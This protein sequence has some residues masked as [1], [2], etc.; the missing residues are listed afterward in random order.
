MAS[1]RD[2]TSKQYQVYLERWQKFCSRKNIDVL[3]PRVGEGIEFLV[4]LYKSGLGY[5]AINTARSALSSALTIQEGGTFGVHP[6]VSR[7]MKGIFELKPAL[8]RYSEIW[9]VDIVLAYLKGFSPLK[10]SLSFKD[11]T[12]NLNMLLCLT[13]GQR[14]QTIHKM[15]I[16]FIQEL[17]DGFRIVIN[18]KIKQTKPGKHLAPIV[19]KAYPEDK[20]ICV[21]DY[22]KEYL[23]RTLE[24]RKGKTQLLISYSKPHHPISKETIARW[25]K[26][27]LELAGID[28]TKYSSHSSRAAATSRCKAG[29]LNLTEI[30]KCAGWSS[31]STFAKYY[32]KPLDTGHNFG[33][34]MLNPTVD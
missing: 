3:Q 5:S 32:D 31:A 14:G 2:G 26:K 4:S 29:G 6:L 30:M 20:R 22:L 18:E 15:N 33:L 19:L 1:W 8:P 12:L 7:C 11:L 16:D 13:T 27:V 17:D 28:I 25:A 9:D 10:G 34:V 24:L 21:V 23:T